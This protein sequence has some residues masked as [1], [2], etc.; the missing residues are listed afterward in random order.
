MC[1][2]VLRSFQ[3]HVH[4]CIFRS[5]TSHP[6][7]LEFAFRDDERNLDPNEIEVK[8]IFKLLIIFLK[9]NLLL[10]NNRKYPSS[11]KTTFSKNTF[12]ILYLKHD[13][14]LILCSFAEYGIF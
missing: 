1:I 2:Y 8:Y 6:G 11:T 3:I 5:W 9:K 4:T 14:Q 12:Q 7:K 10:Q 13:E